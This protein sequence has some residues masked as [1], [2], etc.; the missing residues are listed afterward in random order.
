MHGMF[1]N[2]ALIFESLSWASLEDKG[3]GLSIKNY[4]SIFCCFFSRSIGSLR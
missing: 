3:L 2:M 1:A 4:L